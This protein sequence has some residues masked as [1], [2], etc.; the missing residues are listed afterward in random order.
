MSGVA[1][2]GS[3]R[4]GGRQTHRRHHGRESLEEETSLAVKPE[5]HERLKHRH[6]GEAQVV[7]L[8][9]GVVLGKGGVRWW[10]AERRGRDTV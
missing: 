2:E 9:L 7:L 5:L 6:E 4:E 10:R 8:E 1:G 3:T